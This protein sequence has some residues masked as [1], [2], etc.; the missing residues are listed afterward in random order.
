MILLETRLKD[1]VS[2]WVGPTTVDGYRRRTKSII[3]G[4][5]GYHSSCDLEPQH[6]QAYHNV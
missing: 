2:A 4:A 3:S 6:I 5:L 1:H